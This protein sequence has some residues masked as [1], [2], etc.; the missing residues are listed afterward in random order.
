MRDNN[1]SVVGQVHQE[2]A[3]GER[4]EA[5]EEGEVCSLKEV[6]LSMSGITLQVTVNSNN[7]PL[8]PFNGKYFSKILVDPPPP[9]K[10]EPFPYVKYIFFSSELLMLGKPS[11]R[12]RLSTEV[13]EHISN[14]PGRQK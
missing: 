14:P 2:K 12:I 6:E 8:S 3:E 9:T 10:V 7:T 4:R 11:T 13:W 5:E 1:S